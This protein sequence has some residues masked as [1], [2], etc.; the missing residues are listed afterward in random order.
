MDAQAQLVIAPQAAVC[1]ASVAPVI[2]IRNNGGFTLTSLDIA[3]S[4]DGVAEGNTSWTGSLDYNTTAEITLA[5]IAPADGN[6]TFSF[7]VSNPNGSADQNPANDSASGDFFMNSSGSAVTVTVGGGSWDNEWMVLELNG[8]V[9][10]SGGAG[11]TTECIPTGCYTFF[12]TDSYNDGWN[13]AIYTLSDDAGNVLATGSLDTAQ[14]GDGASE[15]SDLVQ[16]GVASC[17]FGCT[18]VTACN[19][20][21][22][23]TLEDGSCDFSCL[24]CTDSAACNYDAT[25]TTDDGTCLANDECGGGGDEEKSGCTD[26]AQL[27]RDGDHIMVMHFRW[28]GFDNHNLTDNYPAETIGHDYAGT[29]LASGIPRFDSY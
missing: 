16:L 24:G 10:A 18:D 28:R 27:R 21:S 19:Y 15:G 17:G 6:H 8:T 20:D 12:M 1:A 29:V 2:R 3:Y 4:I 23:A 7:T 25:A 11:T 5:D 13:G 9:Y 22:D 26:A 14:Q